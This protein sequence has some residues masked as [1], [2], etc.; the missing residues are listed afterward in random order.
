MKSKTRKPSAPRN[1]FVAA[2]KFKKAGAHTKPHKALRRQGKVNQGRLAHLVEH[3]AFNRM[4]P[5]SNLGTPTTQ[6]EFQN[7]RFRNAFLQLQ[8][9]RVPVAQSDRA[10]PS[11]G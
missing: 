3:P 8:V 1:P 10:Q 5:S 7:P 11:E 4:V 9:Q 2:A 6:S